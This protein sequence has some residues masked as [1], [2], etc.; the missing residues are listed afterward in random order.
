[1]AVPPDVETLLP[2]ETIEAIDAVFSS[3]PL[4]GA[5]T[6]GTVAE[7]LLPMVPSVLSTN[8]TADVLKLAGHG[9]EVDQVGDV[10]DGPE[11]GEK[12][13][14]PGPLPVTA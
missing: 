10:V 4:N 6:L 14:C 3:P 8:S 1:V 12:V 13:S 9:V 2:S 7:A 11:A 5:V